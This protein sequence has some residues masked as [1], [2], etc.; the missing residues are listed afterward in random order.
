MA[1]NA[2]SEAVKAATIERDMNG[3]SIYFN[4]SSHG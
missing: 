2:T 4:G 3:K 1:A